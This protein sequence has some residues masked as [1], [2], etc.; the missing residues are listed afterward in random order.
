MEIKIFDLDETGSFKL[1]C[2]LFSKRSLRISPPTPAILYVPGGG[3]TTCE[4]EDQEEMLLR[5]MGCGYQTFTFTYPVGENYR[6]PDVIIQLSKALKMIRSHAEEWNIDPHRIAVGGCS[7][8]A[9]ISGALSVLWNRPMIQEPAGCSGTENCPDVMLL[10][11]GPMYCNQLT[12]D[13]L[14]YVPT[15]DLIGPHTPPTFISHCGDDDLVPVDQTLAYAVSLRK[16]GVPMSVFISSNGGHGGLQNF[17]NK[18]SMEGQ[19]LTTIDE[20]FGSFLKFADNSCGVSPDPVRQAP[21]GPPE[22]ARPAQLRE[23]ADTAPP[24]MPPLPVLNADGNQMGSFAA[25]LKLCFD[26]GADESFDHVLV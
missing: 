10:C 6:F 9:H 19:L 24:A 8:G 22:E 7:A 20:W 2:R 1:Y 16:A 17:E 4:P 13:G 14:L 21:M 5:F 18:A 23:G 12:A 15:G 25:D 11:Y 3:F 26:G